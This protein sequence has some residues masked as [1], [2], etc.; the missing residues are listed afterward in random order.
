RQFVAESF[1]LATGGCVTGLGL[2]LALIKV[3]L[4]EAP[5]DIPRIHEVSMDWRV[6]G[7][8]AAVAT[9]TGLIFGLA[10]AWHASRAR[11]SESLRAAGRTTGRAARAWWRA[12]LVVAEVG[13]SL[14]LL[15]GAGL[16]L[17]SFVTLMGIDLGF[18]PER[19]V[20]M[21]I[22]LPGL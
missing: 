19:V 18:Q 6:F 12:G 10:P 14:M 3:L 20:A 8:A 13:L 22:R 1:L 7:A 9:L 17:K 2:G 15:I 5:G 11:A 21:N 4:A 16:L